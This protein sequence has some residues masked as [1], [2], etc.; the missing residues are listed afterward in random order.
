[1]AKATSA[2]VCRLCGVAH[3]SSQPHDTAGIK[4]AASKRGP[5]PKVEKRFAQG[6]QAR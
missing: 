3:W 2:P 1:M 5:A 4:A 6:K